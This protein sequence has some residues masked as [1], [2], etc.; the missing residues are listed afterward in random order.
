MNIGPLLCI[1]IGET[2]GLLVAGIN[3]SPRAMISLS[4][5]MS[6]M[7]MTACLDSNLFSFNLFW[8]RFL[9][10]HG[11]SMTGAAL[12][13][14]LGISAMLAGSLVGLLN[15]A[16]VTRVRM[17]PFMFIPVTMISSLTRWR[18]DLPS[19]RRSASYHAVSG[20]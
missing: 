9:R 6:G 7:L 3:F 19:R 18:S 8:R 12:S 4:S 20:C 14:P 16:A 5:V 1:A 13:L 2:F 10:P 15:G 11:R 17:P